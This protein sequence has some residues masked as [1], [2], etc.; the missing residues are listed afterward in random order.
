MIF[1]AKAKDVSYL[2]D[3]LLRYIFMLDAFIFHMSIQK[4]CG[5]NL[6]YSLS[7]ILRIS[8]FQ[9]PFLS[10]AD[11]IIPEDCMMQNYWPSDNSHF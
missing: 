8:H 4:Q 1:I 9:P 2:G 11:S 5:C 7:A 6:L 10:S 3:F